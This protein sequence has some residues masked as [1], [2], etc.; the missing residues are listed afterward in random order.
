MR[1]RQRKRERK[2]NYMLCEWVSNEMDWKQ[3]MDERKFEW[4]RERKRGI[5]RREKNI[6]ERYDGER[7]EKER[8][9]ETS[10]WCEETE[11]EEK[12]WDHGLK[13]WGKEKMFFFLFLS[14]SFS[15]LHCLTIGERVKKVRRKR[16]REENL[17]DQNKK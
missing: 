1:Q 13:R 3:G 15:S 14:S 16:K 17:R 2:K 8:D 6:R 12:W 7:K 9:Y 10:I 11:R 4:E 5:L